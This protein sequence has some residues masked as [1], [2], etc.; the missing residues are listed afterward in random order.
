M[1]LRRLQRIGLRSP[2]LRG[3]V[4]VPLVSLCEAVDDHP[5]L[6]EVKVCVRRTEGMPWLQYIYVAT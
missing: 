5:G 2:R 1:V 4:R 3:D 6:T